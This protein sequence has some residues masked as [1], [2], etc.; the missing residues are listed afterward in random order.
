[1]SAGEGGRNVVGFP[2]LMNYI[3]CGLHLGCKIQIFKK[4]T[5]T[6][7]KNILLGF[8]GTSK[9]QNPCQSRREP[10]THMYV[11]TCDHL[12]PQKVKGHM[13]TSEQQK[14]GCVDQGLM[15]MRLHQQNI[16]VLHN[17]RLFCTLCSTDRG[18]VAACFFVCLFVCLFVCIGV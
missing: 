11:H 18:F 2:G 12:G 13:L 3:A 16:Q 10:Q 9:Q 17:C 7:Y 8:L 4:L 15:W 5:E 14:K 6:L 1:M